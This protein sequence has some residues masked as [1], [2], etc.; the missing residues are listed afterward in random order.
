MSRYNRGGGGAN[1]N[2]QNVACEWARDY[3]ETVP[4]DDVS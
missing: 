3:A 4:A 1:A 2:G